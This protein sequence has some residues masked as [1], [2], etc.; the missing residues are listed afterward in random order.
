MKRYLILLIV[1]PCA[2]LSGQNLQTEVME[3]RALV[4]SL[5][6]R[7]ELL[8]KDRLEQNRQRSP[9]AETP[10]IVNAAAQIPPPAPPPA[11]SPSLDFLRGTT[12]NYL[13]DVYY[14]FN[15]NNPIGRSNL[16]RAYDVSS[17]AFSLNQAGVVI[18]NAA[19]PEH[20]K[21]F[22]ARVDFQYGQATATLQGNPANEPRPDIYRSIFQ[23]Y[24]TYVVPV[25]KGLTVDVG[26]FASS[27]GI[28]NNYTKDQINYS[29]SY[30]FAFLPFYHMGARVG[31][32]FNDALSVNYWIVNGTQQT[33][34]FNGFKDQYF[35]LAI[36]PRKN[37]S[38]AVNYYFGQEHPDVTYYPNGGA[39]PN[40]P[41]IQGVPF[42]PITDAPSGKL[43]IFDSY[44]TW[45]ATP[46][47]TLALEGDY[48]VQRLRVNSSPAHTQ[49]VAAYGRYQ[50]TPKWA[51]GARAEYIS[52]RGGL[53]SGK[54]QVL[55]ET[56]ATLEYKFAEGF[57]LRQEWRRDASNHPYFLTDTLGVLKKEQNTATLGLTWWFGGKQGAW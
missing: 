12:F 9:V 56:T 50:I 36:Q 28:E 29:R 23:A 4:Q 26:K 8:E 24:G 34:P 57:L 15:F 17:N 53:F 35:G 1:L 11:A 19:D 33:E 41:T 32:K 52:D 48:V 21:R 22:G 47:L 54:D 49:G 14:G 30:L 44:V 51:F 3:L 42:Q 27:L 18:E 43:H 20:G 10:A 16:L 13:V 5:Q 31:Y 7:I 2:T 55:K 25:G 38:W 39:P 46:K 6:S 40:S 45:Q 37:V